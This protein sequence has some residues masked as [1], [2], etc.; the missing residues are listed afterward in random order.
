MHMYEW[1]E[2][3]GDAPPCVCTYHAQR[4]IY[5]ASDQRWRTVAH[6]PENH[7]KMT[8]AIQA[9]HAVYDD[10]RASTEAAKLLSGRKQIKKGIRSLDEAQQCCAT[11]AQH[12][13]KGLVAV[14]RGYS[15]VKPEA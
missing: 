15:K 14:K 5:R 7:R 9:A 10:A 8:A 12:L 11:L 13:A 3:Y 2:S 1:A 6:R 4:E